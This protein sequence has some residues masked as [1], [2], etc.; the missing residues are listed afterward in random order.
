MKI[1]KKLFLVA[2]SAGLLSV[3]SQ[4]KEVEAATPTTLYLKPN[5]NWTQ[6]SARFA[7]YFFGNGEKW[8]S[9]T[10]SDGDSIY[11]VATP[12]GFSKVIF[13]RMNPSASANNWN[14]K[15]NQT[16]DL[17]IPTDGKNLFT[18]PSGSWDGSTSTWSTYTPAVTPDPIEMYDVTINYYNNYEW[19]NVNIHTW[20]EDGE[21]D[22]GEWPGKAMTKDGD[23]NWYSVSFKTSDLAATNIIFNNGAGG[24]KTDD[25]LNIDMNKLYFYGDG[26]TQYSSKQEIEDIIFS[27]EYNLNQLLTNY[28][29]YGIYERDTEIKINAETVADDLLANHGGS[30]YSDL[31]HNGADSLSRITYFEGDQLWMTNNDGTIN[32][33]YGTDSD[34]NL[35]HFTYNNGIKKSE[36]VA[37]K[38]PVNI[39]NTKWTS[40]DAGMEGY[41]IT[42]KDIISST[43]YDDWTE[44]NKIY[45]SSNATIIDWFKAF[46]A[47]CYVGFETKT[48]NYFTFDHV[49]IEEKDNVLE[50]RLYANN[51]DYF[52]I[53]G[54]IDD[55]NADLF[56]IATIK[57]TTTHT[58]AGNFNDWSTYSLP[59]HIT[60]DSDYL[61]TQL[62][63]EA[64]NYEFK[65]VDNGEWKS[66]NSTNIDDTTSGSGWEF[67]NDVD[68]NTVLKASGGTYIFKL[69][70]DTSEI[71]IFKI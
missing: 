41:Y 63:L 30:K 52:K 31:F 46:T 19:D 60:D 23:T 7:A 34:G 62:E 13:C 49:E 9:M 56:S 50:L 33:G 14:N 47:P 26:K 5:S 70:V 55:G 12:A 15:W 40:L 53:N 20:V 6:A 71:E 59:F 58:L 17:N 69:N 37:S 4:L 45:K 54:G 18:I 1:I 8:I 39:E 44:E 57:R 10:D 11:E 35:T 48:S 51:I 65:Y 68:S 64:G 66:L 22:T 27:V 25:L 24:D 38:K 16:G 61:Y 36:Y 29:N 42:L 32:S 43:S 2:L 67:R 28:Y 3:P 21:T